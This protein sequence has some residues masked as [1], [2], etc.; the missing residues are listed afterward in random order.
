MSSKVLQFSGRVL[1]VE[2]DPPQAELIGRML[3]RT[4]GQFDIDV[5]GSAAEA[6]AALQANEYDVVLL[7]LGLPDS[8]GV[9]SVSTVREVVPDV[10]IV[11]VTGVDDPWA[12]LAAIKK[13]A[14]DFLVK[15]ALHPK[16]LL[17]AIL[18]A[19]RGR[20]TVQQKQLSAAVVAQLEDGVVVVDAGGNVA[21]ANPAGLALLRANDHLDGAHLTMP[22]SGTD[23]WLRMRDDAGEQHVVLAR[24]RPLK[25]GNEER[26]LLTLSRLPASMARLLDNPR[27]LDL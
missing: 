3:K 17:R 24:S 12:A 14:Q 20:E 18:L 21:H 8:H 26:E 4:G 5:A 9:R 19:T 7:D 13:G 15:D 11:V 6:T 27:T 22:R 2:D 1:H 16:A 25:L 23:T 10:P